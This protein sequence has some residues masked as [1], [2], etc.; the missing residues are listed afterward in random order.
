[1]ATVPSEAIGEKFGV[2]PVTGTGS[3]TI[4]VYASPGRA[5]FG[6]QL[7]LSYDSGRLEMNPQTK[8]INGIRSF[9][10]A[11]EKRK[12][13]PVRSYRSLYG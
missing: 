1:M 5:G 6:L 3:L 12:T 11:I 10:L 4:R 9:E 7:S 8:L 13:K 2:N